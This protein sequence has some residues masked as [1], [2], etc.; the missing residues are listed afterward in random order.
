MKETR[1]V[2]FAAIFVALS[3]VFSLFAI[4]F[5][6]AQIGITEFPIMSSGFVLGPFYGAL[7]GFIKDVV[8]AIN[9]GYPLSLFTFSPIILGL[10]PGIF[11]KVFGKKKLYSNV[12]LLAS[13]IYL[14]TILRT[15]NNS[16]AL[17]Y[18]MAVPWAGI[19]AGLTLRLG[20]VAVEGVLYTIIFRT[21]LPRIDAIFGEKI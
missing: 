15:V 21:L 17:Y 2:T 10:I 12:F 11:L 14:T 1:R 18:V 6:N 19:K 16:F 7:V 9:K 13:C 20:A 3:F 5:Y 8:T 4:T